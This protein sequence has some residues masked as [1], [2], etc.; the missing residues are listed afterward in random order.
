MVMTLGKEGALGSSF[1]KRECAVII[2]LALAG[3]GVHVDL[4]TTVMS[5]KTALI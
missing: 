2:W 1:S 5:F 3:M 4:L